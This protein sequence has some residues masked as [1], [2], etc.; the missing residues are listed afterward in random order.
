MHFCHM[1]DHMKA[2]VLPS[3]SLTLLSEKG[4]RAVPAEAAIPVAT[5]PVKRLDNLFFIEEPKSVSVPE[6]KW[7][8]CSPQVQE[9]LE[10]QDH[11]SCI[12]PAE[13]ETLHPTKIPKHPLLKKLKMF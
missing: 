8:P 5:P 12:R 7:T 11:F 2:L 1:V 6:S 3:L 13:K 4:L 10:E 9:A